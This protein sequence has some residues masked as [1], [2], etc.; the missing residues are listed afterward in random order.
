[1]LNKGVVLLLMI[2]VSGCS[3][4]PRKTDKESLVIPVR[5]AFKSYNDCLRQAL[6]SHWEPKAK[7]K[8]IADAVALKCEPSLEEYKSAVRAVY[9][10]G[11]DP[12]M[13]GYHDV[14]ASKPEN[15]ANR[16]REKGKSAVVA[17]LLD[18]RN[19][20]VKADGLRPRVNKST[21]SP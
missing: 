15:H 18:A 5:K 14:L 3:T 13:A 1:M 7:P 19:S 4:L 6:N 12:K 16:I 8:T 20:Q 10:E 21:T 11:L 9:A 17:R 2:L